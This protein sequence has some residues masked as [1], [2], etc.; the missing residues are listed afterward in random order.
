MA[1]MTDLG[2]AAL[3][4]SPAEVVFWSAKGAGDR[5]FRDPCR[6]CIQTITTPI[7]SISDP[8]GQIVGFAGGVEP[9]WDAVATTPKVLQ[10]FVIHSADQLL[11][12]F[13]LR[14]EATVTVSAVQY[15]KKEIV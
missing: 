11:A 4:F 5:P 15:S 3:R 7:R 8:I 14:P 1:A 13:E 10:R 12:S 9:I 2:S 6:I